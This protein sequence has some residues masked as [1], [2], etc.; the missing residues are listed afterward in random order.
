MR[1]FCIELFHM[2]RIA[3]PKTAFRFPSVAI[4]QPPD[5]PVPN[6]IYLSRPAVTLQCPLEGRSGEGK[7]HATY[8]LP[9]FQGLPGDRGQVLSSRVRRKLKHLLSISGLTHKLQSRATEKG[10]WSWLSLLTNKRRLA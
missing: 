3:S 7:I 10:L 5:V 1:A 6:W 2:L 9:A 4:F 8:A